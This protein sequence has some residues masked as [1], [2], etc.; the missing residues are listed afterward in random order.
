M[1]LPPCRLLLGLI[2]WGSLAVPA[3]S[4]QDLPDISTVAKELSIPKTIEGD[5]AAGR[6]VRQTTPG[7]IADEVHHTLWLPEDWEPGVSYPVIFEYP[8]NDWHSDK[9]R[10]SG[11]PESC[12]LGFGLSAGRGYI[13]VS[14]PFVGCTDEGREIA[15]TWWGDVEETKRYC[16]ATVKRIQA[17]YGGDPKRTL[18]AGFSRGAIA[19]NFI[20]LHDDEIAKLWSAFFCHSHYDGVR[21]D[22]P[23]EGADR[24]SAIKRL[25][26]LGERPLWISHEGSVESAESYLRGRVPKTQL[27]FRPLPYRNHTDAWGLRKLPFRQAARD[28]LKAACPPN[29]TGTGD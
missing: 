18:L 29:E 22:W 24:P 4:S 14:L 3:W 11:T 8:G 27:T 15:Q 16:R 1:N 19:C 7:W 21:T 17:E 10:Y 23:Y 5:P 13:W 20:G 2:A 28:W 9:S 26:R 6:R 25:A 12:S